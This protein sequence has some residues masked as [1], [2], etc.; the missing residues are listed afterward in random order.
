MTSTTKRKRLKPSEIFSNYT[1]DASG[2]WLWNGSLASQGYGTVSI[3]GKQTRTHRAFYE[4]FVKTIPNRLCVCHKCDMRP[5][6][7]PNH[8][9]LGT[10]QDN[11]DDR[12]RKGRNKLPLKGEQHNHAKLTEAQ[13]IE[14]R[15]LWQAGRSQNSL[16]KQFGVC[17]KTMREAVT[18][19]SWKSLPHPQGEDQ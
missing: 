4:H 11:V 18:G 1:I 17:A 10:N 13:V 5:C 3:D 7:N 16:A 2:C 8:L 14:A 19:K 9:F 12:E 15:T 6:V